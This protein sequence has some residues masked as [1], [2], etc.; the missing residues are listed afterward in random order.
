MFLG[1]K[2]YLGHFQ[3]NLKK[4]NIITDITS[5]NQSLA[6]LRKVGH[7]IDREQKL[8]A[9][10]K[11]FYRTSNPEAF[12]NTIKETEISFTAK[13]QEGIELLVK[14][15]A[16]GKT[17]E[18]DPLDFFPEYLSRAGLRKKE[19][20]KL[21]WTQLFADYMN[22]MF[23]IFAQSQS[24]I[25]RSLDYMDFHKNFLTGIVPEK[26]MHERR[27]T[28]NSLNNASEHVDLEII[29]NILEKMTEEENKL[30][31]S[32]LLYVSFR[33]IGT[34]KFIARIFLNNIQKAIGLQ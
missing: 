2:T 3:N 7:V 5:C 14:M 23:A 4:L 8:D 31:V 20:K 33:A 18:V 32:K 25:D 22:F 19:I 1:R 12:F 21:S 27:E 15:I 17:E 34:P 30:F 11:P 10:G 24:K 6:E 13:E 16:N 9:P 26:M 29:K 28:E